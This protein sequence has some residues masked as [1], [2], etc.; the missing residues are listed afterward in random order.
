[1]LA[2]QP[3]WCE[4][5]SSSWRGLVGVVVVVVVLLLFQQLPLKPKSP[6]AFALVVQR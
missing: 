4:R 3:N 5:I 6:C 1:M 2:L